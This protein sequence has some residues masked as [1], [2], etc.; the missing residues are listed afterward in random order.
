MEVRLLLKICFVFIFLGSCITVNRYKD[1]EQHSSSEQT[2]TSTSLN[3]IIDDLSFFP[4]NGSR[5]RLSELKDI[6]AVVIFMR[7]SGCPISEKYGA[8]LLRLEKEYSKKR[9]SV[10]LQLC[11]TG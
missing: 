3:Q 10:Y 8:R 9:D 4:I 5:F 7:E 1:A 11:W 2:D 6:K